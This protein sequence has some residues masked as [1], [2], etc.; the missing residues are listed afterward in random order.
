MDLHNLPFKVG[1]LVETRSFLQ[2]YRGAWFRCKIKEIG[3]RNKELGHALEYI[4]FPDEKI[5]WT[6]LYQKSR[7]PKDNK[8]YLM[9][10]PCFPS[11]YHESQMPDV[12]TISETV[13]IVNDSWKVGDLVDWWTDNC[14]WTGTIIEKLDDENF[15]IELPP[16]PKGEGCLYDVSCKDLRPS[17]DWSVDEGW[18]L[19][20][21]GKYHLYC[22]RIV[23][24]VYQGDS[25][26]LIDCIVSEREKDVQST[27]KTST[28]HKG[29][30]SSHISTGSYKGKQ[31]VK[32]SLN[33]KHTNIT[34][35]I[36]GLDVVDH[37]PKKRNCSYGVSSP[38]IQDAS[39][40][41][42]GMVDKYDDSGLKKIKTDGSVC[43]NSTYSDTIEAAILDLEELV[44]RVKWLKRILDFGTPLSNTLTSSWKFIEHRESSIPK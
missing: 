9:V 38:H 1:Q 15:K 12:N 4:D 40:Q 39:T 19:P 5:R 8:R 24:P 41:A 34:K 35:K 10:R 16:P 17:L 25:S 3:L 11:V 37:V 21:G 18:K 31:S 44:C 14:F 13:V 6:K 22:A 27:E 7:K 26:N 36:V 23:K 20:K 33:E 42:P 32:K 30:L 28:K 43:L 29:S 2:G